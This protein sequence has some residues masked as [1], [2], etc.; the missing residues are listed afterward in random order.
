MK[1]VVRYN[2]TN[3]IVQ[4][5]SDKSFVWN[6]PQKKKDSTNLFSN[7]YSHCDNQGVL[8]LKIK[9]PYQNSPFPNV[10]FYVYYRKLFCLSLVKEYHNSCKCPD[11]VS[12]STHFPD[13]SRPESNIGKKL[14]FFSVQI[15]YCLYLGKMNALLQ[16]QRGWMGK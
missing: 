4:N 2:F 13:I 10:L 5:E 7:S 6:I 15:R 14:S 8:Y 1:C 16:T 12:Y 9:I 3:A 11:F